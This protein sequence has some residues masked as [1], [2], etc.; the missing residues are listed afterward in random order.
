MR[1]VSLR[2]AVLSV[3]RVTPAPTPTLRGFERE[4]L[5]QQRAVVAWAVVWWVVVVW[6]VVVWVVVVW[7][8][9]AAY[10]GSFIALS[11]KGCNLERIRVLVE[12]NVKQI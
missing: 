9:V 12:I 7:V 1:A 8:G 11:N 6:V 3:A 5:L 4:L 2:E 10:V